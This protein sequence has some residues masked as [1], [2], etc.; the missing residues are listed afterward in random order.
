ML[1]VAHGAERIP[2]QQSRYLR[3]QIR[4][5]TSLSD[6]A[7]FSFA[8]AQIGSRGAKHKS[9]KN[10]PKGIEVSFGERVLAA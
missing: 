8:T 2:C 10:G 3:W 5:V 9:K 1:W 6:F 7:H 4:F